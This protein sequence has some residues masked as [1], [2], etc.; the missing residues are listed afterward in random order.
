MAFTLSRFQNENEESG[1]CTFKK[2]V[3]LTVGVPLVIIIILIIV[4]TVIRH[5]NPEL[6]EE[7]N[8]A[9]KNNKNR[10]PIG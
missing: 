10:N 5:V 1:G 6:L 3:A 9:A 4:F 7:W 8:N 2:K